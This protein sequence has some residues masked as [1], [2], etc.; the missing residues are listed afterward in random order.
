MV[1]P[2]REKEKQN[3]VI[4]DTGRA[5]CSKNPSEIP[6]SKNTETKKQAP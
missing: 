2:V 5:L 6:D 1:E 3:A 4:N